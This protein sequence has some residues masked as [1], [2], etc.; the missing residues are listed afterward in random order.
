MDRALI[1]ST[2]PGKTFD[3]RC[4]VR[5]GLIEFLR[6]NHPE[7]LPKVRNVDVPPDEELPRRTASPAR[8][9]TASG[10]E[11]ERGSTSPGVHADDKA[12]GAQS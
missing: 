11:H 3:L 10:K 4:D 12:D 7:S 9:A 1:S 8:T 6:R 2:T 5:E